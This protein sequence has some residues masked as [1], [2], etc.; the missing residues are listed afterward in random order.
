MSGLYANLL[1]PSNNTTTSTSISRA[2]I[3]FKQPPAASSL[4]S[5]TPTPTEDPAPK[6]LN[7]GISREAPLPLPL[8]LLRFTESSLAH[9]ECV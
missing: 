7:A 5:S 2:P 6:K 3:V 9:V 4:T 8:P 1:D